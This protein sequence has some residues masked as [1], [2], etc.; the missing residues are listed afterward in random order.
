[1]PSLDE[2]KSLWSVTT[3]S[4]GSQGRPSGEESRVSGGQGSWEDLLGE[5][6]GVGGTEFVYLELFFFCCSCLT[7]TAVAVKDTSTDNSQKEHGVERR[8][9]IAPMSHRIAIMSPILLGRQERPQ[10]QTPQC[11]LGGTTD[12]SLPRTYLSN[13]KGHT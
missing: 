1:M 11:R 9:Q 12:C 3:C 5:D 7:I 4:N 13:S 2:R 8:H 10:R 6:Q